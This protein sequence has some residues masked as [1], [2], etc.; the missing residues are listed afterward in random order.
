LLDH[1]AFCAIVVKETG[2]KEKVVKLIRITLAV[3]RYSKEWD[4]LLFL[5]ASRLTVLD[6]ANNVVQ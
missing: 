6:L 5:D 3:H 2:G 4:F 1:H